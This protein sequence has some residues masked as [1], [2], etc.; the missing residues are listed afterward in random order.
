MDR[1]KDRD[2]EI[3]KQK[4]RGIE[5]NSRFIDGE[6]NSN[7]EEIQRGYIERRLRNIERAYREDREKMD[8]RGFYLG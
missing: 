7:T 1:Q 3:N 8:D 5:I 6:I 2:I 4:D